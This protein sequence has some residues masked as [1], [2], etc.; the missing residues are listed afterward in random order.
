MRPYRLIPV[1]AIL[2]VICSGIA[3]TEDHRLAQD[4]IDAEHEARRLH[5]LIIVCIAGLT[6][7]RKHFEDKFLTHLR[8]RNIDGVTSHSLVPYLDKVENRTALLVALEEEGIDGAITVRLVPLDD[9]SE[10]EW[11][12]A[13]GKQAGSG[14]QIRDLIAETLP[15]PE[16]QA[17][18]YGVEVA[19][20]DATDWNMIWAAR[21]DTYKRRE[22]KNSAAPFVQRTMVALRDAALLP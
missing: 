19:L 5:K 10:E 15:V 13:W 3:R 8:G 18:V 17:R 14:I 22:L 12:E 20:W 7:E 6:E 4:W 11:A 21:T 1:L 9:R 16:K 2:C